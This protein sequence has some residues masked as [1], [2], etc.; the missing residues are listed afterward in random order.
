MK[1]IILIICLLGLWVH[2]VN[3]QQKYFVTLK[4]T[5]AHFTNEVEVQD[6]S[7]FQ[8]LLPPVA[9]RLIIPEDSTGKFQIRFS[10]KAPNYFRIG[11]NALYLSP[12]DDLTVFI[13]YNNPTLARFKGQGSQANNFLRFTPCRRLP[14]TIRLWEKV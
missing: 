13:D 11:R 4:G 7:E 14:Y 10:L 6:M 9:E 1:K 2:T 5:L 3:A 8:Y 12:G